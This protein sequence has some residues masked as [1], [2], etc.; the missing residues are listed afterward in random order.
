M[1]QKKKRN[2]VIQ[3]KIAKFSNQ[4]QIFGW[5][6]IK[7]QTECKHCYALAVRWMIQ[8]VNHKF[9]KK[10]NLI[11]LNTYIY[12]SVASNSLLFLFS[13]CANMIN[14]Q[15]K[16]TTHMFPLVYL[17]LSSFVNNFDQQL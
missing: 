13:L 8:L 15:K 16:K 5:T 11:Y 4:R 7:N 14:N 12:Q 2:S 17:F 10:Q 6:I 9:F 1:R 3:S